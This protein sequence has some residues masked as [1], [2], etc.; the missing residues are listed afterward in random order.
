MGNLTT[1]VLTFRD[2]LE[3]QLIVDEIEKKIQISF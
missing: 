2:R 1:V 3:Q